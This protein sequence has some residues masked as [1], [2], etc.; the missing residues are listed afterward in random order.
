MLTD[1]GSHLGDTMAYDNGPSV[2]DV[3]IFGYDTFPNAR[4]DWPAVK[5]SL[6]KFFEGLDMI[7]WCDQQFGRA[8]WYKQQTTFYF[9]SDEDALLFKMRYDI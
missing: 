2:R 6:Y 7:Q 5:V 1:C 4:R 9:N 3:G 8:N